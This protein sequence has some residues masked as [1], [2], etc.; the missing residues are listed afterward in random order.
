MFLNINS[1]F[2]C[3]KVD[4]LKIL[5]ESRIQVE[6]MGRNVKGKNINNKPV[7]DDETRENSNFHSNAGFCICFVSRTIIC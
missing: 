1:I 6:H 2:S 7:I 5:E 4:P 3:E